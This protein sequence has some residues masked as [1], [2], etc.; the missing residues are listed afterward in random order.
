MGQFYSIEFPGESQA[1][2]AMRD[3]LLD[4]EM[5]LRKRIEEV[6]ALPRQLPQGAKIKEDYLFEEGASDLSDISRQQGRQRSSGKSRI[7]SRL[8]S[9]PIL[10][11][12]SDRR[13]H[14]YPGGKS[15]RSI[16]FSTGHGY[17]RSKRPASGR[18]ESQLA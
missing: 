7:L 6:A 12:E 4:A 11:N 3:R 5:K 13:R 10:Q 16:R 2:R 18:H 9:S 17:L 8:R 15:G 14:R 1:Y